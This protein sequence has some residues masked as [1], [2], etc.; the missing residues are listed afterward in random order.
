MQEGLVLCG[1]HEHDVG[2]QRHDV[3]Q[4]AAAVTAQVD[5]EFGTRFQI[6]FP[7]GGEEAAA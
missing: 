6:V 7:A 5:S 4:C 3:G 2:S 1:H